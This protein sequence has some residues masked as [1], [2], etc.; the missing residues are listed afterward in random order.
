MSVSCCHQ[1]QP[2][3]PGDCYPLSEHPHLIGIRPSGASGRSSS[4]RQDPVSWPGRTGPCAVS[5][6]TQRG[7][8]TWETQILLFS[9]GTPGLKQPQIPS[10]SWRPVGGVPGRRKSSQG[11]WDAKQKDSGSQWLWLISV[12]PLV[13]HRTHTEPEGKATV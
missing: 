4:G 6:T 12:K 2:V 8:N 10:Y 3:L 5:C 11:L 7:R 9:K 1:R 13:D